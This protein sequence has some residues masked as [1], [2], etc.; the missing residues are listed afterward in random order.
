MPL[1]S[2]RFDF[3]KAMAAVIRLMSQCDLTLDKM[4]SVQRDPCNEPPVDDMGEEEEV[5]QD[6]SFLT[7]KAPS[8]ATPEEP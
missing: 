7:L 2:V 1:V 3:L 5:L 8:V 6:G 4:K